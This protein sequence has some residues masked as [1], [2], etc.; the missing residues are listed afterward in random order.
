MERYSGGREARL[1]RRSSGSRSQ[2]GPCL[3]MAPESAGDAG[4]GSLS[5]FSVL[6]CGKRGCS[7]RGV[8]TFGDRVEVR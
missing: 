2:C 7:R 3:S 4:K 5:S 6:D 1:P 8:K